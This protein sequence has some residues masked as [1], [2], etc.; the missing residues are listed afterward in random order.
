[1]EERN[2]FSEFS[3]KNFDFQFFY[4]LGCIFVTSNLAKNN[5]FSDNFRH[6]SKGFLRIIENITINHETFIM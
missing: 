6:P 3:L 1:M 2:I 4:D 5:E